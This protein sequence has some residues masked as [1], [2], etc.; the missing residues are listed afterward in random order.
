MKINELLEGYSKFFAKYFAKKDNPLFK[1]LTEKGQ[2]PKAL[3][4]ACCDSRVDP[5][6]ITSAKPGDILVVRNVANLIPPYTSKDKMDYA[7]RA[8]ISLAITSFRVPHIIVM[9][10]SQCLGLRALLDNDPSKSSKDIKD[11][12]SFAEPAK[13]KVLSELPDADI[14]QL[15]SRCERISIQQSLQNLQSYPRVAE[16][17]KSGSLSLHGWHFDLESGELEEIYPE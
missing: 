8:A 9:G 15:A 2:F 5:A 16:N 4:I 1:E 7:S 12:L 13:Q 10:H 14:E 3:I 11:W 17:I 6:I